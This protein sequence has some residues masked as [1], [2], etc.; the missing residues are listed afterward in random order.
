MQSSAT[1][2]EL[3]LVQLMAVESLSSASRLQQ[4]SNWRRAQSI[5]NI[6]GK[7]FNP[8]C[9]ACDFLRS[10]RSADSRA[11]RE[12]ESGACQWIIFAT[13]SAADNPGLFVRAR[14]MTFDFY[15]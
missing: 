15:R 14:L 13:S 5:I 8:I 4:I 2:S 11:R 7:S 10:P 6:H 1:W 9:R 3:I 12:R